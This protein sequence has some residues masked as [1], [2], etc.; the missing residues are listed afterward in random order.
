MTIPVTTKKA[1]CL[2]AIICKTFQHFDKVTLINLY[3]TYVAKACNRIWER[4]LGTSVYPRSAGR[5]S[6]EKSNQTDK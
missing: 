2:V 4:Y 3:K 1:N 5:E 6:A